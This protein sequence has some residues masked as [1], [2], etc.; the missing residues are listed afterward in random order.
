MTN[1]QM[2]FAFAGRFSSLEMYL[3]P[4]TI[5]FFLV[6]KLYSRVGGDQFQCKVNVE[7]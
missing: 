1:A 5:I 4:I 6:V 2:L 7:M 3:L